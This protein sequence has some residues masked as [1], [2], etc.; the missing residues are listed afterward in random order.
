LLGKL[1]VK[2]AGEAAKERA[3]DIAHQL[4]QDEDSVFFERV[5]VTTSPRDGQV[6]LTNFVRKVA[7]LV[8]Q[9]RGLLDAY[10]IREQTAVVSNYFKA[11][12]IVFPKEFERKGSIFFKTVGFGALWN[13]FPN[14]FSQTLKQY[15]GFQVK[16]AAAV[17][18]KVKT[19]DFDG[20]RGYGSGSQAELAAAEDLRAALLFAFQTEPGVGGSLKV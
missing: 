15:S 9:D 7:P 13:V 17:F 2:K 18:N 1:P 12:S 11:L 4:K 5:V 10:T 20:W 16:D 14:F 19:F 6:S 8:T 3:A